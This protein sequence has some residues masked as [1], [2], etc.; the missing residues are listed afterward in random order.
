MKRTIPLLISFV[1]VGCATLKTG[2]KVIPHFQGAAVLEM[3]QKEIQ[4]KSAEAL[5]GKCPQPIGQ[6]PD[7]G[8]LVEL[9]AEA[10]GKLVARPVIWKGSDTLSSCLVAE[11]NKATVTPLPGPAITSLI[12][13]GTFKPGEQPDDRALQ[14]AISDQEAR[15][16][17]AMA[18]TCGALLPPE[19][20]ADI[21]VAF[22]IFPGGK[23]GGL[24]IVESSA[25]DGAFEACVAKSLSETKFPD[26]HFDGPY[27]TQ[28]SYHF[29]NIEKR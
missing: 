15:V 10:D 7:A 1:L 25:K 3:R 24:N 23:V 20:P 9:K 8:G 6:E 17:E 29:G 2:G 16:K 27:A 21:K 19:F 5:K 11:L 12:G 14:R 28:V 22:Y 18:T 4:A 26:P 13:F